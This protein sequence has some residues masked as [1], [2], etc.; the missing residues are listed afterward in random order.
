MNE[1]WEYRFKTPVAQG[2]KIKDLAQELGMTIKG[3]MESGIELM[4]QKGHVDLEENV[5]EMVV[6]KL[7]SRGLMVNVQAKKEPVDA[8]SS[9]FFD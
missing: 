2:D 9:S 6:Q 5:S 7:I 4:R 8:I 1:L 3:L